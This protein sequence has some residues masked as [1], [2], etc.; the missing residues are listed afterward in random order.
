MLVPVVIYV[1][2]LSAGA[3]VSA[4]WLPA[5]A[6]GPI[7]GVAFFLVCGLLGGALGVVGLRLYGIV[8]LDTGGQ[9]VNQ[10]AANGLADMMWQAGVLAGLA[11]TV[12]LL[13]P[14]GEDAVETSA[15]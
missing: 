15:V 4:Q 6:P 3:A 13:A 8:E 1:L 9:F 2:C 14:G 10:A 11:V 7:G 5:L 12:Y